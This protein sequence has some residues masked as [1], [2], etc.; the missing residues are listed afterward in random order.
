MFELNL[1]SWD[2]EI[3]CK[4][5]IFVVQIGMIKTLLDNDFFPRSQLTQFSQQSFVSLEDLSESKASLTPADFLMSKGTVIFP[6]LPAK[7][8]FE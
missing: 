4:L 3:L 7:H 1:T 8:L 6:L 2:G 5:F